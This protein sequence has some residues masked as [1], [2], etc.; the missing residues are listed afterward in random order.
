VVFQGGLQLSVVRGGAPIREGALARGGIRHAVPGCRAG[1]IGGTCSG[2]RRL[3]CGP[4]W[5]LWTVTGTIA[6]GVVLD[7]PA[8]YSPDLLRAI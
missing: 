8:C 5:D 4:H 2:H 1:R 3:P 6:G 7:Q